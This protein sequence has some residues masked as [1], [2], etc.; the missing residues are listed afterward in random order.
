MFK[1]HLMG[2]NR[3][4]LCLKTSNRL[5]NVLKQTFTKSFTKLANEWFLSALKY[6]WGSGKTYRINFGINIHIV[7]IKEKLAM[8]INSY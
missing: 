4:I 8:K 3:M 1:L 2:W 6:T 7:F 5:C